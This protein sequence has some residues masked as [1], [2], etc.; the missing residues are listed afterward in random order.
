MLGAL[1]ATLAA[2]PTSPVAA[3]GPPAAPPAPAAPASAPAATPTASTPATLPADEAAALA[4][5]T[6]A[7]AQV[8][9][10]AQKQLSLVRNKSPQAQQQLRQQTATQVAGL[11]KQANLTEA[12][13]HRRT[14][15]VSTDS[16][17][18]RAFD[19]TLVALTTS[20]A[21]TGAATGQTAPA[22]AAPS[23]SSA[24]A[25]ETAPAATA[26]VAARVAAAALPAGPLGTH[27]GHVLQS[28]GDTPDKQGLLP[29]ATAEARTAAAHAGLAARDLN[30]LTAMQLHAGHVL[31]AVSP[32]AGSSGPG[33]GYGVKRAAEG[34]AA[35]VTMAGAVQGA[36]A[37]VAMHAMHV[38]TAAR[39]TVSR[40]DQIATLVKRIQEAKTASDASA[41]VSQLVSLANE[42]T[43]GRDADADGRFEWKEPEGGLQQAEEHAKL[44]VTAAA[45]G[46]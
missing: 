5:L 18:R 2:V 32:A 23:Q 21:P 13:Y 19:A 33:L 22:Q 4:R 28:F 42:L 31:H 7:I 44:L 6:A 14:Y 27:L 15:L 35:H 43:L 20:A 38:A 24:T 45:M 36:P 1:L 25:A 9:D 16:A 11:L 46:Q 34:V 26:P 17:A 30:D 29:T 37:D 8:R 41:L 3:Q 40:A 39:T 12:E 10:S